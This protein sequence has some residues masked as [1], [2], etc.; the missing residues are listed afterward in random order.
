[1]NREIFV[2]ARSVHYIAL[3]AIVLGACAS[4]GSSG[5]SG[6]LGAFSIQAGT[7]P[8]AATFPRIGDGMLAWSCA[9]TLSVAIG[10]TGPVSHAPD[11]VVVRYAFDGEDLSPAERWLISRRSGFPLA[12]L[13]PDRVA[14]FTDR[15][16]RASDVH[17]EAA[18]PST[19][20]TVA[21]QFPLH[22]SQAAI[23]RVPCSSNPSH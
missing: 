6:S 14:A 9:P 23:A 22:G 11:H 13:H 8:L 7:N 21:Y 10:L 16:N 18:D 3:V 12:Y 4:G 5:T 2:R 20:Q 17:V 15:A 1:M 19:R